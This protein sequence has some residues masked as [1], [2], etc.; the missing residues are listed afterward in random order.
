MTA[1]DNLS[2]KYKAFFIDNDAGRYF[3]EQLQ[4]LRDSNTDKARKEN[5]L[6]FLSRST[7]NQEAL[8]LISNVLNNKKGKP[9]E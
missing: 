4:N 3:I 7:G 8:D 1:P 5:S 9:K 6:D 2:D